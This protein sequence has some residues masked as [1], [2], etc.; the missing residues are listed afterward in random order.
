M[1]QHVDKL[2][3]RHEDMSINSPTCA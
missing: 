2:D 1:T 3:N